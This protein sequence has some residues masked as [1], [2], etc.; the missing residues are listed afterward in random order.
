MRKFTLLLIITLLYFT[1]FLY[2]QTTD[3]SQINWTG[4]L[5]VSGFYQSGNTNNFYLQGRGDIKRTNKILETILFLS[6]GYGES[7]QKKNDNTYYGSLTADVYYKKMFSP[8]F[9]QY[10][11]YNFAKGIDI[12]SQTGAGLKYLFIS[13]PEHKSSISLAVV[14]DY[15]KLTDKP[16]NTSSKEA[17]FSFRVKSIQILFEKHLIFSFTGLYQPVINYFS[18]TNY[19]VESGLEIPLTRIFRLNA[20]YTY[21]FDNVVS[22]GRKRADNKMTFGAGLKF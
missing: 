10:I 8:F 6:A 19:Y 22:V 14:Y 13:N 7:K 9:L 1:N 15:L 21:T 5:S 2:S 3:T 18:K 16:G 11:E 17:R 12:R 20:I 4:S